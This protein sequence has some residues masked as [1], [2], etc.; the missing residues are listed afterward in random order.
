MENNTWKDSQDKINIEQKEFFNL[1]HIN[2]G[3]MKIPSLGG[4][5]YFMAIINDYSQL[6]GSIS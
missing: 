2:C 6:L 3:S 1:V 5:K 4:L